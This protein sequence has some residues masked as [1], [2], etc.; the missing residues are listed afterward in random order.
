[1]ILLVAL[2]FGQDLTDRTATVAAK[3]PIEVLA[4]GAESLDVSVRRLAIGALVRHDADP[5]ASPWAQR[6]RYDPS[7]YVQR[8]TIDALGDKACAAV[9][10]T[11]ATDTSLD[12]TTRALAADASGEADPVRLGEQAL[13]LKTDGRAAM[14]L[15]VAGLHGNEPAKLR[16][17]EVA[18]AGNL[19]IER[20]LYPKLGE[21]IWFPFA[22]AVAAAEPEVRPSVAAAW[23]RAN[24]KAA[25]ATVARLLH[26]PDEDVVFDTIEAVR[27]DPGARALLRGVRGVDA[28]LAT[29]VSVALAKKHLAAP[30]QERRADAIRTLAADPKS[31]ALLREA[32][33][34]PELDDPTRIALA[35]AIAT[36]PD[37]DDRALLTTMLA[38]ELL[39]VRVIAA[40]A[41]LEG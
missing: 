4:S 36:R 22:D 31:H 34:A 18:R 40:R 12:A 29:G 27:E 26:D 32:W 20:D 1:M 10:W 30:E 14:F 41:L 39:D 11:W 8:E 24:P 7:E 2:A 13:A 16:L 25:R 23:L 33:A 9:L 5:C 28:K 17:A 3:P 38:H 19:P 21:A 35:T 6:G 37:A 15:L